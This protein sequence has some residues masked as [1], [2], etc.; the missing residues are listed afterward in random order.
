MIQPGKKYMQIINNTTQFHIQGPTALTI[1]KFDGLH[2]GHQLILQDIVRHKDRGFKSAVFTFD[3]PPEVFFGGMKDG[4]L[5]TK[6]EKR[7]RFE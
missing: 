1:G 5:L 2:L 7:R 4:R 6:K 3:P